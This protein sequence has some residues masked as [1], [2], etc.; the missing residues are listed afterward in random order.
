MDEDVGRTPLNMWEYCGEDVFNIRIGL[1]SSV[2]QAEN[3]VQF[4]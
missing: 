3:G 4:L 2:G 1:Q